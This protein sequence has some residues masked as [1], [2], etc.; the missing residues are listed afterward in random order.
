M[1]HFIDATPAISAIDIDGEFTIFRAEEIG[2]T[3]R[4]ALAQGTDLTLDLHHVTEFDSAGLQLVLATQRSVQA[5]AAVFRVAAVSEAVAEVF[6][7]L[8]LSEQLASMMIGQP[9]PQPH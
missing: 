6:A 3:L 4:H 1:E 9:A 8:G 5:R 2:S 7:M